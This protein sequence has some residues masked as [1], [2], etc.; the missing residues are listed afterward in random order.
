MTP[1]RRLFGKTVLLT[2]AEGQLGTSLFRGLA[3]QGAKVWLVDK[4]QP[5]GDSVQISGVEDAVVNRVQLDITNEEAVTDFFDKEV[6][7]TG[8]DVLVNNAGVGVFSHFYDRTEEE[9][10]EVFAVNVK[11]VFFMIRAALKYLAQSDSGSIINIGSVYGSVSSDPRIYSDTPRMN[12][13]IYSASKAAVIQLSRYFAVHG[14]EMGVRVNTVSP[15]GISSNQGPEFIRN[16][17]NRVPMGRMASPS[18]IVGAVV[19]FAS[20]DSRYITGQNLIVD[21][22]FTAW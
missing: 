17:E 8:L 22:G 14:A 13:E 12:S 6:R 11:G 16:Y 19:F 5:G 18:D 2:G 3:D 21:G 10:D 7:T 15:G 1:S 4:V 9:F 20:D